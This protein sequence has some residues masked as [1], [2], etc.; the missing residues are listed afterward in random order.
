MISDD[1]VLM[2]K[3]AKGKP[4]NAGKWIQSEGLEE[5]KGD[6]QCKSK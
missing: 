6:N 1:V 2:Y 3:E 5:E 4:E